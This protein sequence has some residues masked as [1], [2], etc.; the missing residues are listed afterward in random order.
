MNL[1]VTTPAD[2]AKIVSDAVAAAIRNHAPCFFSGVENPP[3]A[4]AFGFQRGNVGKVHASCVKRENEQVSP[5]IL[6]ASRFECR[7]FKPCWAHVDFQGV[8][9]IIV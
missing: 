9:R 6:H 1:I 8:T 3:V 4:D 7:G 2:L 5:K